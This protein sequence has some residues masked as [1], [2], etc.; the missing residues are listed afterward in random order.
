MNRNSQSNRKFDGRRADVLRGT[1]AAGRASPRSLGTGAAPAGAEPL[2]RRREISSEELF[3]RQPFTYGREPRYFGTGVPGYESGPGFTGGY[4]GYGDEAPEIPTELE[5]EYAYDLY[6]DGP[7]EDWSAAASKA[8]LGAAPGIR[9]GPK[10]A[11]KYPPG[12]KGY[13]RTD[14]RMRE[15]ICDQLMRTGHIDSS[16][17][18]VEV[19]GATVQLAG[20]VPVRWM[21]H[22]IENLADACPGVQDIENRISVKKRSSGA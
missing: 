4:Y 21:K 19:S 13:Q 15:D 12:P 9:R 7:D 8:S 16:D 2:R 10:P 11:P 6:G 22:V 14:Q 18:T 20:S 17:V 5:R 3:G 1:A